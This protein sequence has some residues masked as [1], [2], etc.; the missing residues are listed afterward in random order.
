MAYASLVAHL[1]AGYIAC[2][3][4]VRAKRKWVA[5][6]EMSRK[7][8]LHDIQIWL[9]TIK[10]A[11]VDHDVFSFSFFSSFLFVSEWAIGLNLFSYA[12]AQSVLILVFLIHIFLYLSNKA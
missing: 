11:S 10:R 9:Y 5:I 12:I 8:I 2:I 6:E 7:S 4:S 1:L 3:L